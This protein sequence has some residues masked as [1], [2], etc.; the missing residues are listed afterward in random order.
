MSKGFEDKAWQHLKKADS[1]RQR[2]QYTDALATLT[3]AEQFARKAKAADV[4]SAVIGTTARILKAKGMFNDALK[5]YTAALNIQKELAKI[6]PFFNTW[7]AITL[8]NL[9][10]LLQNMGKLEDAKTKYESVLETYEDLLETDPESSVYQSQVATTLNNL[11]TLLQNMGR[12]EDA[13]T[14]YESAL[15]TYEDLLETDPESSVY[16]SQVATTL[17][18]LGALLQNMGRPED[19]KTKCE[20]ALEMREALLETDPESSVYQSQVAMTLN[21]LSTLLSDMGRP[22]EAKIRCERALE[23]YENLLETDPESSVYQSWVAMTLNNLGVLLSNIGRADEAKTRCERAL[24]T[25]EGLLETDP[26]SSV[27]Q[28]QVATTLNNLGNLLSKMG[29]ADEAK[30]RYERGLKTYEGLLETDP[31]SSVYQSQVATTLN[32]LGNLLSKMGR[33]DEAKIRCERALKTYEDL[34]ET[35]PESSVYQSWVAG[36]LNNLGTLLSDMGDKKS[37]LGCYQKSLGIYTEPMQYMTIKAKARAIINI[38]QLVSGC[39]QEDTH[40][41]RKSNYFKKVHEVYKEHDDFFFKYEL[42]HERR[43]VKEAGLSA[44]IQYLMLN[45]RNEK[46]AEKRIAEYEKCIQEIEQIAEA[47][48]DE[49]LKGLWSSIMYY[50]KGRQFVNMAMRS[51]PPDPGLMKKAIEQFKSAKDR[52]SQANVCYCI[53]TVLLE[54]ESIEVLDDEAA[55]IMKKRLKSAT[56]SLPKEMDTTVKSAFHEIEELLDNREL[57]T[58]PEMF[59]RL[60][61]C[62][63]K[64]DYYALREH[65]NR[66]SCKIRT[67][68][69]EPFSPEVKYNDWRLDITFDEPEKV[70]GILTI[71]AGDKVIFDAPLGKRN[72]IHIEHISETK[73]ETITFITKKGRNVAR[74]I[75]YSEEI[76]SDDGYT[77]VHF[78]GHDCKRSIT[79]A[80]FNIA[81]VQLKYHLNKVG[82]ALVIEDNDAYSRKVT[83]ILEAVKGKADLIVFPE[84]SIP[85]NYLPAMKRYSDENGIIIVAGSHYVT[86]ATL[87]NYGGM[88]DH[89]FCEND[90]LKNISPVIM[91]STGNILH[92]EKIL[93]AKA[94]R[95]LFF[96]EGMTH[97]T[98]NRIFKLNDNVVFG[99][100]IC[101]DFINDELR[102]RIVDACNIILVPQTNPSTERFHKIGEGEIENPRGAGNKAFIMANGI[103]TYNDGTM[104]NDGKKVMGGD[105]GII[106][107]LDKDTAK[108]SEKPIIN[109]VHEQAI[110]L[111]PLNMNFFSARDTQMAQAPVTCKLIHIFEEN[112]MLGPEEDGKNPQAFLDL[113]KTIDSCND[114]KKLQKLLEYEEELTRSHSPLMHKTLTQKPAGREKEVWGEKTNQEKIEENLKNLKLEQIKERCAHIIV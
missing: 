67:Y 31:E 56:E 103:F 60:N 54:L 69:E 48:D 18:N 80:K 94:E 78:L 17:N 51:E 40:E 63:T 13:K 14:K 9:G 52:Y 62:I 57:K 100:M 11:G 81:I 99:V 4:L 66:I 53:Y 98:L 25:Y 96:D 19:A 111:V 8:N 82:H 24:K 37:A 109:S 92:T 44:H 114:R 29:R 107:T 86:D 105:S 76:K 38:I 106:L 93:P 83:A 75:N 49:N 45:A 59:E 72:R 35:D 33:P 21:N 101:F 20:S 90:L 1:Q 7:V 36:T 47:E 34:L 43:L 87:D 110:M 88:F 3:K 41:I 108:N 42:V 102:K 46:E 12:L 10:A 65:F 73:D 22:D 32:N 50:L 55:S 39:A 61:T 6:D 58:N 89:E 68:L 70:Q 64:I 112:E 28:S 91:P 15:E 2:G 104:E 23:T 26:E 97:G 5:L 71:K 84:F 95:S 27:Y 74:E 30:T 113:L 77:D 85:S 16:Q 79:G